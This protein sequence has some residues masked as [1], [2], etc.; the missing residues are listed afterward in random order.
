MR[1]GNILPITLRWRAL[2]PI[3]QRY[4]VFVHLLSPE[5]NLV[6]QHDSEPLNGLSPTTSWS[7]GEIIVDPHQLTIPPGTSAGI[8]QIRV[9]LYAGNARL[10]VIDSGTTQVNDNSILITQIEIRP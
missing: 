5:M 2:Q 10:Q 7:T 6:T 3:G 4:T 1:P 8:Y 9:G